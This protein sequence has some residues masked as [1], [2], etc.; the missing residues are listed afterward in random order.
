MCALYGIQFLYPLLHLVIAQADLEDSAKA[1]PP[2]SPLPSTTPSP[3]QPFPGLSLSDTEEGTPEPTPLEE[4]QPSPKR[5]LVE[6]IYTDNKVTPTSCNALCSG[7][8]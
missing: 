5:S 2:V 3:K 1:P 4:K 8:G 6:T 7:L